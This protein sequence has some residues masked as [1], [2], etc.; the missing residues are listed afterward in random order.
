MLSLVT[1]WALFGD[2]IRIL[3]GDANS[4]SG[5]YWSIL[6]CFAIFFVEICLSCY[7]KP[8]YLFSFFFILDALSTITLLMDVGWISDFLLGENTT[9]KSAIQV[10]TKATRIIRI[11]RLIRLVRIVKLYKA[12]QMQRE[13][14]MAERQRQL[15]RIKQEAAKIRASK[16]KKI[17]SRKSSASQDELGNNSGQLAKGSRDNMSG[18]MSE[19][20]RKDSPRP[21]NSHVP[22]NSISSPSKWRT[23]NLSEGMLDDP[24]SAAL[25]DQEEQEIMKESNIHKTLNADINK[26]VIVLI[27]LIML[28]V[29]LFSPSTYLV[30]GF[31][32]QSAILSQ[33]SKLAINPDSSITVKAFSSLY[34]YSQTTS[35]PIISLLLSRNNTDTSTTSLISLGSA[36]SVATY[37]ASDL[38]LVTSNPTTTTTLTIYFSSSSATNLGAWLGIARTLFV[39]LVLTT[40]ILLMSKDTELLV[41]N[42]L[43]QMVR[44]IGRIS[45][46]P[47]QAAEM[48]EKEDQELKLILQ[49]DPQAYQRMLE[50]QSY[51]PAILEKIVIKIGNL[52]AIGFG[53]AG[54]QIIAQN[55]ALS[56]SID[57]MLKGEKVV[58]IF[59]FCDI[60]GFAEL[61]DILK[62]DI[63]PFV[64]RVADI[65]HSIVNLH[66]GAANK[67]IGEAFLLTWRIPNSETKFDKDDQLQPS[68]GQETSL[69]ADLSVIS[70]VKICC[71]VTKSARLHEYCSKFDI[72]SRHD[73]GS[74][75]KIE[76]GF[77]LH[78][79]WAIEGAIGSK[80]KIDAS[81]LSPNVNMSA[82]LEAASRQFGVNILLSGVLYEYL[83]DIVKSQL[84]L[85]DRVTVKGSIQPV[86]KYLHKYR[87][88]HLRSRSNQTRT[89]NR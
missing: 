40:S 74:G 32:A 56:G 67:N 8:E 7:A 46:N 34:N 83:S 80:F 58:A 49:K 63:M 76:M 73:G 39:C 61:T 28:S 57:P 52:L 59:G 55:M 24:D 19:D 62:T 30:N 53:E 31:D 78:I 51:E 2:D 22:S 47:L 33:L 89:A 9:N 12:A 17:S 4:D 44:K 45:K 1:L 36:S 23:S 86:G 29:P 71:A 79:G 65:V 66:Q 69:L 18:S 26:I 85:I 81:Y 37:R 70:F 42:P 43:E 21:S 88:L 27:L 84:R 15:Q 38:S 14:R 60:R 6:C 13:K 68:G 16:I 20:G 3:T 87:S 41:L 11:I 72:E 77:G 10:G 5:F 25:F 35:T 50:A 48:E 54:S 82:R 64:N 75:F